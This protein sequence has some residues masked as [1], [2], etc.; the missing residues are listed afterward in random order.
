M[1]KNKT[2]MIDEE[3]THTGYGELVPG[4]IAP[5]TAEEAGLDPHAKGSKKHGITHPDRFEP[6]VFDD[7]GRIV[8]AQ[9]FTD[10]KTID[11]TPEISEEERAHPRKPIIDLANMVTDRIGVKV[12]ADDPEYWGFAANITDEMAEVALKMKVRK[13][14][15]LKQI[16]KVTK[17]ND[18]EA[19]EK[20]LNEMAYIG[21]IEYNWENPQR[22]KQYVLPPFVPGSA[23][24]FNSRSVDL[25]S[26][27]ESAKM[28]ERMTR[29][30]LDKVTPMVPPGGAGIGM[31]VIPVE[32]AITMEN[33][34]ATVEHISHWLKKYAPKYAGSPCSC[35]MSRERL[36]EGCAD[37]PEDWCIGV[38][39]MADWLV[40]TDRGRYLSYDEVMEI[41]KKAEDNGFVHQ[42]T[43][44][45][46]ENKIFAICNCN[47]N[48]CYALRTSQLYNT[49]NMSRS[50]YTAKIEPDKCVA[51]GRCVEVCP[52]GAIKLGQKL[53]SKD[54]H[55]PPVYPKHEL[56]NDVDWGS[57]K[58]TPN[59][60]D[61]NRIETQES[62]T[63][64]CKT[65]CPAHVSVQGYLKLAAQGKYQ[66]ALELIRKENPLPAICGRIC[67]RRCEDE[68]TRGKLDGAV[69]IDEVKKFVAALEL[70]PKTRKTPEKVIPSVRGEFDQKIAIVGSGPA[71]LSCAYYLAEKG[72]R[73]TVFEKSSRAGGMLT[74]GIPS[75]KLEKDII[76]AEVDLIKSMGVDIKLNTEVGK[77]I[78]LD[79]LRKQGYRA[80]YVAIGCQG[81][82][83]A[84]IEGEEAEGSWTA[85]DF[86]H[87]A[88][89]GELKGE[90]LGNV[91][92]IGGG[93]VAIDVARTAARLGAKSVEMRCLEKAN[94]MPASPDEVEEATEDGV[95]IVN[96]WGPAEVLR[97]DAGVTGVTF[98]KCT[99]VFD[100]E[101][102]FN[103]LY[104]GKVTEEVPANTVVFSVGQ[105]TIWGDLLKGE[106]MAFEKTGAPVIDKQ[107]YQT[108]V[109]D[110]FAGGDVVTGPR[111]AIDAIAQGHEASISIHRFVHP[112]STLT[113]GRN[114]RYYKEFDK[115]N[116]EL[117]S[118]DTAQR[119]VPATSKA[120]ANNPFAEYVETF[121]ED[122]V[123]A[124]TA[125]CL[126][127]G[128]SYVDPN[129][130]IGCGLCTTKCAFD[131]IHLHRD[132][133]E[134]STM[135]RSE[136]KLKAIAP[137]ALKRLIRIRKNK[138]AQKK[139]E[140]RAAKIASKGGTVTEGAAEKSAATASAAS[141]NTEA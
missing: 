86:L 81:S 19:L 82:R 69:A 87:A 58:W 3:M 44:I 28:F 97:D 79:D 88:A 114:Q 54:T 38:G 78:T 20:L 115:D 7:E 112:G 40:E 122:Q 66:E 63:A 83:S 43:N 60:R 95:K 101:G 119:N 64:P 106:E 128:V 125:R 113:I 120:A 49:P 123:K 137:Y 93:N 108:S 132:H 18:L 14:K 134:N 98:K 39:D 4:D 136:D 59:Y 23:E 27:P 47:V 48:V 24:F 22:E 56:P 10:F 90:D 121:T 130:C 118:Y 67:N 127:C 36:G 85:V 80:F 116:V 103:P 92:V 21:L 17:R 53:C 99:S 26:H 110:I 1:A 45:D 37:D 139:A 111:F 29:L 31:H 131:A 61:V 68:C 25:Q 46:G 13:P 6:A 2:D 100:K 105:K 11:W 124:E 109:D 70:D 135:Y 42:I 32:R 62:G 71:G 89:E 91:V 30:P 75:Y 94:E 5:E 8:L 51:C 41:L 102:K 84:G 76:D 77:D 34:T 12:T 57:E 72:Y 133:P 55:E 35:R 126:S 52:A 15:T 74:Y 138:K 141:E 9:E 129:K 104:D 73:P 16:A 117:D 140:K 65:A 96:S 107:T 50:A 33:E